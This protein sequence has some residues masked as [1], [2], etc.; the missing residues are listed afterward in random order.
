MQKYVRTIYLYL[1][2]FITLCMIIVGVIGTVSSLAEYLY[3]ST[4]YYSEAPYG[5]EEYNL[6][7][8]KNVAMKKRSSIKEMF[9]Y[10][11]IFT[12]ATPLFIYHFKATSNEAKEGV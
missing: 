11:S 7:Y 12:I 2:S 8:D 4:Y 9:T 10:I 6:G 3:P 5:T 1:V